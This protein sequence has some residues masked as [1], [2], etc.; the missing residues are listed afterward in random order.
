M[1]SKDLAIGTLSITGDA[2]NNLVQIV[3]N[4][5][6]GAGNITVNSESGPK[7]SDAITPITR[8][9]RCGRPTTSG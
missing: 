2:G 1:S 4:G 6:G 8:W 3:D 7:T 9:H 5:T